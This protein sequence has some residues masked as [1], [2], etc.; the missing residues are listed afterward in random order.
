MLQ[1]VL[2]C[3]SHRRTRQR[4]AIFIAVGFLLY[5]PLANSQGLGNSATIK[6]TVTDP[7]GSALVGSAIEIRNRMTG[8]RRSTTPDLTGS[9]QF[10]NVPFNS[11]QL[12]ITTRGFRTFPQDL[13]AHS[14]VP[15]LWSHD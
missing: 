3:G 10:P 14:P 5:S 6:G 7:T 2:T 13:K 1:T 11:Y 4:A 12:A 8:Y 9:F 15:I